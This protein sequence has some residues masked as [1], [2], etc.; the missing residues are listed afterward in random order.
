MPK[1]DRLDSIALTVR[2]C[3]TIE[4][5]IPVR[6]RIVRL[7]KAI[8]YLQKNG[9]QSQIDLTKKS[10]MIALKRLVD[11]ALI[12]YEKDDVSN[13]VDAPLPLSV[14]DSSQNHALLIQDLTGE[15]TWRAPVLLNKDFLFNPQNIREVSRCHAL[16]GVVVRKVRVYIIMLPC[17]CRVVIVKRTIS[18]LFTTGT[19]QR[20]Q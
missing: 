3:V 16:S 7:R 5:Q 19:S 8:G 13:G 10:L 14:L 9:T 20:M 4:S 18:S 11:G 12:V 6:I 2:C 15:S 1:L 17:P